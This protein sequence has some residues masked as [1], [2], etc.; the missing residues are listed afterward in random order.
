MKIFLDETKKGS[1]QNLERTVSGVHFYIDIN[2][3]H[4]NYLNYIVLYTIIYSFI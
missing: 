1:W 3:I 2:I 4:F